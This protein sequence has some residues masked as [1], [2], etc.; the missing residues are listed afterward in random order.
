MFSNLYFDPDNVVSEIWL[1]Y[2]RMYADYYSE[3][4]SQISS[5]FDPE[6]IEEW[7]QGRIEWLREEVIPVYENTR[8]PLSSRISKNNNGSLKPNLLNTLMT[9][10]TSCPPRRSYESLIVDFPLAIKTLSKTR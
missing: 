8:E 1:A 5:E 4:F 10:I 6:S 7:K 9:D 3:E 2:L